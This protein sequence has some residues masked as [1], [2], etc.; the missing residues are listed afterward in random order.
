MVVGRERQ[1]K[2]LLSL[3]KDKRSHF[4]AL[5]GRRRVGKTYLVDEVYKDHMAYRATGIQDADTEAQVTNFVQKVIEYSNV[6]LIGTLSNWQETFIYFKSYLKTLSKKK[7]HVIFIDE[8]PWMATARS[9]FI[10][11]LAHLWNDYLSK[12]KHFVLVVCGSATSW[13]SKKIVND[14][15][16]F[17]N[18][19]SHIIKLEPF[20]L[21]ETKKFLASRKINLTDNA[22]AEIYMTMGGIPFYLEQI[23]KG[24]S[25]TVAIER[26]CFSGDGL[27]K[28]EYDN[29]YKALFDYPENHE[30]IVKA[31]ATAQNGLTREEIIKKSKVD[32]GGPYTRAMDDLIVSGFIIEETPYGRKKR[33]ALYRL[34]DE[35]SVFYHKFIQPNQ[36]KN[37]GIWQQLSSKQTYKIWTGYAFETLCL[38]HVDE[39]K[40]A[41]G[42]T[43]VYTENYSYRNTGNEDETGFQIDLI[44][45]RNDNTINL[46]ECKFYSAEYTVDKKYAS[47][48]RERRANFIKKTKTKK[49]VFNTMITNYP[50]KENEH[51]LDVVDSRIVVSQLM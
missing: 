20:T 48:L 41:L 33:G 7:K 10:Q 32:A 19:L 15:G 43:N 12:E 37:A 5:T 45:D 28:Y 47:H 11:G 31:L 46:C 39:I 18:R 23:E 30:A 49:L 38:R 24:E 9:G 4:I 8:L 40:K 51:S 16:G 14:K 29:L 3:L 22:I 44:I 13:I 36:N 2:V 17:H 25:P 27:L 42:I 1:T 50:I 35:Y 6:P 21:K 34:I 26:L